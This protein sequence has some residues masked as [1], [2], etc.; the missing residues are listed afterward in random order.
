MKKLTHLFII[1]LLTF[2]LLFQ[3]C[4]LIDANQEEPVPVLIITPDIGTT[5]TIFTLDASN[6][7]DGANGTTDLLYRYDIDSDEN[8]EYPWSTDSIIK[9]T[10]PIPGTYMVTLEVKNSTGQTASDFQ[11]LNVSEGN[12][13]ACPGTPTV[14]YQ[15][16][17]YN[18]V[19]IGNQC[20]MREN[21]NYEVTGS[22][23]YDDLDSHC[24]T[25][26]R[27]YSWHAIMN[28]ATA[29]DIVPSGVQGICPG[30]WHIPSF[31]EWMILAGEVGSAGG[32]LLKSSN[33]W[34]NSSLGDN[35]NGSNESGFTAL[36][37]G[38]RYD[39]GT[40]STIGNIT[41][42]WTSSEWP[43]TTW[44]EARQL[45]LSS[46]GNGIGSGN[47]YKTIGIS[48]RCVKD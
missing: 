29:S 27:L 11:D 48:L 6:S 37:A 35:G 19:L 14:S 16:K 1:G 20:W 26:G 22:W 34:N 40:F 8:W 41:H 12:E 36:P 47:S 21:L 28:G 17:V 3:A 39:D 24:D 23:C 25:Y 32:Y 4:N 30:G 44:D 7:H 38:L 43:F 13:Q 2:P 5:E 33:G 9:I 15:G 18:T 31:D 10:Y 42:F 46:D 45:Y